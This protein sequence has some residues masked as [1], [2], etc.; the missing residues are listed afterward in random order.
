MY[1]EEEQKEEPR[2]ALGFDRRESNLSDDREQQGAEKCEGNALIEC[3][4]GDEPKTRHWAGECEN[5]R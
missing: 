1:R 2:M 4:N 3:L 5:E